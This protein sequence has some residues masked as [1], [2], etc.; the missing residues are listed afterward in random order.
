MEICNKCNK[1]AIMDSP[2]DLCEYHWAMWW[3]EGI[4]D[5]YDSLTEEQKEAVVQEILRDIEEP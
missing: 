3:A 4:Y 5:G 2:E 1:P